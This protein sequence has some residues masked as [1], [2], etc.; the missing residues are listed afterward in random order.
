MARSVRQLARLHWRRPLRPRGLIVRST[1]A[2]DLLA[3][4]GGFS[5]MA[6]GQIATPVRIPTRC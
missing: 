5:E 2:A 6:D 3:V 4:Q 1:A